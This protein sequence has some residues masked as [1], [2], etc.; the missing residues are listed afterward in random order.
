MTDRS[1]IAGAS[2]VALL[3]AGCSGVPKDQTGQVR[4]ACERYVNDRLK[5]PDAKFDGERVEIV[6]TRATVGGMVD[7]QLASPAPGGPTTLRLTFKCSVEQKHGRW[8]LVAI[9][10][11]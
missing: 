7:S 2:C 4:A 8:N 6:R 3:L 1:W 9:T 5:S 10:G 11:L